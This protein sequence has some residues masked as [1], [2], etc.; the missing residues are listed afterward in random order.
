MYQTN[1]AWGDWA[2][3][4]FSTGFSRA[5]GGFVNISFTHNSSPGSG[6]KINYAQAFYQWVSPTNNVLFQSGVLGNNPTSN[7]L[8][9]GKTWSN[10]LSNLPQGTNATLKVFVNFEVT[11]ADGTLQNVIAYDALTSINF[12]EAPGQIA[13]NTPNNTPIITYADAH[14]GV[15]MNGSNTRYEAEFARPSGS[16]SSS[17]GLQSSNHFVSGDISYLKD[18]NGNIKWRARAVNDQGTG[19]WSSWCTFAVQEPITGSVNSSVDPMPSKPIH[20]ISGSFSC[21]SGHTIT[22]YAWTLKKFV[23]GSWQTVTTGSSS[24]FA[25]TQADNPS[26]IQYRLELQVTGTKNGISNNA[27]F[28]GYCSYNGDV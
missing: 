28:I 4:S 12:A 27:S 10:V 15:D 14:S 23:N 5:L 19:P 7:A 24:T 13:A 9:S 18:A 25:V 11:S 22:S 21:T 2:G 26:G 6:Y 17:I 16:P 1:K 20:G 3:G 8:V